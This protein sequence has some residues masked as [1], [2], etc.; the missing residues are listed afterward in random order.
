MPYPY[1]PSRRDKERQFAK[2]KQIFNNLQ[3]N[4]PFVEA[5]EQMPTYT[6]FMKELL[7]KKMSFIDEKTIELEVGC[8]AIIQ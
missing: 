4:I 7:T 1:T 6:K 8:N 5:L 2:F 3:I